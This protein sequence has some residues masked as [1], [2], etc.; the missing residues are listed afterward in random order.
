[1]HSAVYDCHVSHERV[2]PRRHRFAYRHRMFLFDLDELD[3]LASGS[4]IFGHNSRRIL[5]FRDCDHLDESSRPL[6]ERVLELLASN[7]VRSSP[8]RILLLANPRTLG[9]VFNPLSIY[10]CLNTDAEVEA[11]VV[12]ICNTFYERKAYVFSPVAREEAEFSAVK[13]FYISPFCRLDDELV[14]KVSLPADGLR[15]VVETRRQGALVL[16]AVLT[17][18]R[19]PFEDRVILGDL[20]VSAMLNFAVIARIHLQALRL[21]LKGIPYERKE[22]HPE[23]QTNLFR[24]HRS[25]KKGVA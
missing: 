17:G 16:R 11:L 4:R 20:F 21:Y 3:G 23:L 12:E 24:P 8:S 1:M 6:K 10:F 18:K 25:L 13:N 9:Y 5:D 2:E 22:D 15:L 14:F 19:S 7:G